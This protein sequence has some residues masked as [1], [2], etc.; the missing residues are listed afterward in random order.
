[1]S[2][3]V[4]D[5]MLQLLTDRN[6]ILPALLLDLDGLPKKLLHL[7]GQYGLCTWYMH[8]MKD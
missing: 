8:A 5:V 6:N 1:M 4:L 3:T 7:S 2:L